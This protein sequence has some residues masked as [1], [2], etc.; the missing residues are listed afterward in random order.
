MPAMKE[1]GPGLEVD[2]GNLD[3]KEEFF[4]IDLCP[5]HA[6]YAMETGRF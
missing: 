5:G 6:G 4:C 2:H 1:V 3:S